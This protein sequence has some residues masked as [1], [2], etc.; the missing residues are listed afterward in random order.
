MVSRPREPRSALEPNAGLEAEEGLRPATALR[1]LLALEQMLIAKKS[2][3]VSVW[4]FESS[5]KSQT[6]AQPA[7][8]TPIMVRRRDLEATHL[9][10]LRGPLSPGASP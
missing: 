8:T 4:D 5:L 9:Q 10:V 2:T 6:G 3:E 7:E 1:R